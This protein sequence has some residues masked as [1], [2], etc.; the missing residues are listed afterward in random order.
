MKCRAWVKP[1][2]TKRKPEQVEQVSYNYPTVYG[3]TPDQPAGTTLC[4]GHVVMSKLGAYDEP[5]YGG[6]SAVLEMQFK[7]ERCGN[8]YFGQ[9]VPTDAD[10]LRAF[11]TQ[12]LDARDP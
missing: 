10:E 2:P 11:V 1:K 5:Y 3:V 12:V 7:C 6:T 9:E 8:T 4:G